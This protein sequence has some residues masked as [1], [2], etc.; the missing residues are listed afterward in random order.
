MRTSKKKDNSTQEKDHFCMI[1]HCDK[2]RNRYCCF[3]CS[4][5]DRCDNPCLNDP[6][7]CGK[8]FEKEKKL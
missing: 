2:R 1:F 5:K 8:A 7:K 3:Y 6:D 4:D